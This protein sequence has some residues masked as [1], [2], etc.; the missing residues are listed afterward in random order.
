[1]NVIYTA[2]V[3][4]RY[5]ASLIAIIFT[6]SIS[7]NAASILII[8]AI[9]SFLIMPQIIRFCVRFNVSAGVVERSNHNTPTPTCGGVAFLLTLTPILVCSLIF[10]FSIEHTVIIAACGLVALLGA[11]DDFTEIKA[12]HKFFIQLILA[13]I[14]VHYAS[15]RIEN[16]NGIFGINQLEKHQQYILSIIVILG[17]T[18]SLNLLDGLDGLAGSLGFITCLAIAIILSISGSPLSLFC[19][20]FCG[21]L[22]GFLN[23]NL[24]PAKIYMGDMGSL[25]IGFI[26]SIMA[27]NT[28]NLNDFQHGW[29]SNDLILPVIFGVFLLPV[30][31]T[32]RLFIFRI[33][34]KRSPFS[35]DR[36][37]IHHYLLDYGFNVWEVNRILISTHVFIIFLSLT[38]PHIFNSITEVLSSLAGITSIIFLYTMPFVQTPLH[39]FKNGKYSLINDSMS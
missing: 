29:F 19:F 5:V 39:R 15:V 20:A 26:T 4:K 36:H 12:H 6:A 10:C 23:F 9:I 24:A 37:H 13:L 32:V 18:N 22:L 17:V 21:A 2:G 27:I 35:P 28:L 33:F 8:H 3:P 34:K 38:L 30:F 14:V 1:M 31:D 25:L 7:V 11:L 16:L